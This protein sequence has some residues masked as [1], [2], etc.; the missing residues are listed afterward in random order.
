MIHALPLSRPPHA[1]LIALFGLMLGAPASAQSTASVTQSTSAQ[2]GSALSVSTQSASAQAPSAQSG[3]E[4]SGVVTGGFDSRLAGGGIA[5]I[6]LGFSLP[7][8]PRRIDGL[9]FEFG[10]YSFVREASNPHETYAAFGWGD[11]L[12]F[13]V[14]RP[15]FDAALD[16]PFATVLPRVAD[17]TVDSHRSYATEAALRRTA[18]PIGLSW[19]DHNGSLDWQIS[20]HDAERGN[21]RLISASASQEVGAL[22]L[23]GAVEGVWTHGSGRWRGLNAKLGMRAPLGAGDAGLTLL[24]AEAN[25]ADDALELDWRYDLRPDLALF[26]MTH[27]EATGGDDHYGLGASYAITPSNS[28]TVTASGGSGTA[29]IYTGLS[30]RF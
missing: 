12:R 26:A 17:E 6:D 15:A 27:L 16:S 19:S 24:H 20:L 1:L 5:R 28:L 18:V 3:P 22:T 13:G 10:L 4:V 30:H 29:G 8:L 2:S 7:V 9:R 14:L 23:A 25:G 21:F 11:H